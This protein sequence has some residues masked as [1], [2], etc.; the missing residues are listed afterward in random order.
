MLCVYFH[1]SDYILMV[2]K[3]GIHIGGGKKKEIE[4]I[5]K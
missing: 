2:Y 4:L 5:Q 3:S 1:I